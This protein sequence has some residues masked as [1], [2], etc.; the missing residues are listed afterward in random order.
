MIMGK[1][2]RCAAVEE[3]PGVPPKISATGL[4]W[5]GPLPEGWNRVTVP[6]RP[7]R[8]ELCGSCLAALEVFIDGGTLVAEGSGAVPDDADLEPAE[9]VRCGHESKSHAGAYG[10]QNETGGLCDCG[11]SELESTDPSWAERP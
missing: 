3:I 10:C 8:V 11:L 1:C 9:C 5:V 7:R 4:A 6:F 2:D